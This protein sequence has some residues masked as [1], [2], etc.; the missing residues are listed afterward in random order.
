MLAC[1][2][3]AVAPAVLG[4]VERV[5]GSAQPVVGFFVGVERGNT[6]RDGHG[7]LL[8]ELGALDEHAQVL[9]E[10]VGDVIGGAK[11]VEERPVT[12]S[13][14]IAAL[15]AEEETDDWLRR[16]DNALYAAKNGGRNRVVRA[17]EHEASI[18][19]ITGGRVAS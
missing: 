19:A 3:D 15:Y 18:S 17:R 8:D 13:V 4:R 12:I 7:A 11:L 5:V 14:G 9:A 10:R 6:H 1:A 16:T 2:D